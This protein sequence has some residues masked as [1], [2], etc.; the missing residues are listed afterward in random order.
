MSPIP[1][2][3]QDSIWAEDDALI[4]AGSSRVT[5][6]ALPALAFAGVLFF[7]ALALSVVSTLVG[8]ALAAGSFLCLAVAGVLAFSRPP[9][10]LVRGRLL[11]PNGSEI[12]PTKIV[13]TGQ[14]GGPQ[15]VFADRVLLFRTP[16]RGEDWAPSVDDLTWLAQTIATQLGVEVWD[17][18]S[19]LVRRWEEEPSFRSQFLLREELGR[20][21]GRYG[22]V[23]WQ[24]PVEP[25]CTRD[26]GGVTFTFSERDP[27]RPIGGVRITSRE[28]EGYDLH[29]VTEVAVLYDRI[30]VRLVVL[31]SG[32]PDTRLVLVDLPGEHM[33]E[34]L[35]V[36][37]ELKQAVSRAR[38]QGSVEDVPAAMRALRDDA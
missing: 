25:R 29:G 13:I 20:L 1:P 30:R 15:H 23:Y 12:R 2:G 37:E 10:R 26:H 8:L 24:E 17:G 5:V 34:V 3:L 38:P 9:F 22:D 31:H 18:R 33:A 21:Q 36:A 35:F 14:P 7:G 32:H 27:P 16:A 4:L 11:A 6:R 19:P 28:V